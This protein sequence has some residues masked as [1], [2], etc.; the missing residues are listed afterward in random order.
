[1]IHCFGSFSQQSSPE[2]SWRPSLQFAEDSA[3]HRPEFVGHTGWNK[4]EL[5]VFCL[6]CSQTIVTPVT[7]VKI[8]NEDSWLA[9]GDLVVQSFN[10]LNDHVSCRP[11][12]FGMPK[13]RHRMVAK[14]PIVM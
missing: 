3:V 6:C 12:T 7:G 8:H 9:I 14:F 2:L 13:D 4:T 5:D 1:M 10:K 11:P